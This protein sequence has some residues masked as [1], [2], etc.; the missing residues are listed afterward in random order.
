MAWPRPPACPSWGGGAGGA[1]SAGGG[2]GGA[3]EEEGT[4]PGSSCPGCRLERK[5][6]PTQGGMAKIRADAGDEPSAWEKMHK[7]LSDKLKGKV[8]LEWAMTD[9][10]T[11]RA[12]GC[13]DRGGLA[14]PNADQCTVE[15]ETTLLAAREAK[16]AEGNSS[17]EESDGLKA[18]QSSAPKKSSAGPKFQQSLQQCTRLSHRTSLLTTWAP[19]VIFAR[20]SEKWAPGID[21][22]LEPCDANAAKFELVHRP[23]TEE[24][25]R[26]TPQS[27][28]SQLYCRSITLRSSLMGHCVTVSAEETNAGAWG[29]EH[30]VFEPRDANASPFELVKFPFTDGKD[31]AE[32]PIDS[33][34][35]ISVDPTTLRRY[36]R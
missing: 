30:K 28:R 6:A 1:A 14:A 13:P 20:G 33:V 2:A 19:R 25:T 27:I 22:V 15:Q 31:N 8:P 4:D 24:K 9:G 5:R 3:E 34:V 11:A 17:Q 26:S 18:E 16:R 12:P 23:F 21:K 10:N 7:I 36:S 35:A 29:I 32:T